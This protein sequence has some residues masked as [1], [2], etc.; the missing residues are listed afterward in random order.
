MAHVLTK[1]AFFTWT[2][3]LGKILTLDNLRQRRVVVVDWCYMWKKKG[4]SVDHFLLHCEF[5]KELWSFIFCFLG[6]N[7]RCQEG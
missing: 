1:V 3:A 5:A 2:P 4:E 6:C 7:G